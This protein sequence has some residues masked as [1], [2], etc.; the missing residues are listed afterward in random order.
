MPGEPLKAWTSSELEILR[1]HAQQG[2]HVICQMTGRTQWSVLMTARRYRISLRRTNETRGKVL[3]EPRSGSLA[4]DG[5]AHVRRDILAGDISAEQFIGY[6]ESAAASARGER[7]LLCPACTAR[8]VTMASTGLCR[9]C[10]NRSLAEAHRHAKA[11]RESQRELWTERQRN[12]RRRDSLDVQSD[13]E[14]ES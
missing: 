12:K 6:L 11:E 10:H 3:G 8:E 2:V 9:P 5:L 4:S 13:S 7:R 1:T 14:G